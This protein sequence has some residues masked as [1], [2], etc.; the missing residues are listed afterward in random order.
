V[1]TF[2]QPGGRLSYANAGSAILSGGVVV[3]RS[4]TSGMIGIAV[5]DIAATTGSGEIAV[6]YPEKVHVL[7]KKSGDTF[8]MGDICYWSTGSSYI[9]STG[10]GNTRAGVAAAAA[11]SAATTI[12]VLINA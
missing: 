5:T 4:G 1:K 10:S 9:T 6:G 8:A 7:A 12:N 3:V 2:V 11:A